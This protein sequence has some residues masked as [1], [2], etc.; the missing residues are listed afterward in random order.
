MP[1]LSVPQIKAATYNPAGRN[2]LNDGESLY[3][4][5]KPTGYDWNMLALPGS[6]FHNADSQTTG[7]FTGSETCS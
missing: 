1:P 5:L 7:A 2:K 6:N 3:L 4:V